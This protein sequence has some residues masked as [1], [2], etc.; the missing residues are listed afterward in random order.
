MD[1]AF[2]TAQTIGRPRSIVRAMIAARSLER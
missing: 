1:V 2:D